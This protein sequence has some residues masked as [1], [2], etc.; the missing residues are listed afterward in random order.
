MRQVCGQL[1]IQRLGGIVQVIYS[2]NYFRSVVPKKFSKVFSLTFEHFSCLGTKNTAHGVAR[3]NHD[4]F[5]AEGGK[6]HNS[7]NQTKTSL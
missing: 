6:T 2:I 3:M 1:Q 7:L 4:V 5:I